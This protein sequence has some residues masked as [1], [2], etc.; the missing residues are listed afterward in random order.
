[1]KGQKERNKENG[2]CVCCGNLEPIEDLTCCQKCRKKV[3]DDNKRRY[4][5]QEHIDMCDLMCR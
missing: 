4:Q 2:L 5:K 1:M 3:N